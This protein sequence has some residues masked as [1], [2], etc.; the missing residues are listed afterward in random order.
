MKNRISALSRARVQKRSPV[1][2]GD[3]C[4]L[5]VEE[6]GKKGDGIGYIDG[7]VIVIP[8]AVIGQWVTVEI[9]E[10]HETF[11][12]ATVVEE[13]GEPYGLPS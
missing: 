4:H 12:L 11:A 9:D 10:V 6:F 2:T 7:F 13:H 3:R 8:D 5:H 1:N